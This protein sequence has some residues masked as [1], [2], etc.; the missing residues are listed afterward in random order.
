[1]TTSKGLTKVIDELGL[2]IMTKD[3]ELEMQKKEIEKMRNKIKSIEQYIEMYEEFF[4]YEQLL[5]N[6]K[7]EDA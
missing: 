5:K 6:R 7:G 4:N 3:I 2:V 1:M